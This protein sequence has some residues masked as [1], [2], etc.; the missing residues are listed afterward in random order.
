MYKVLI[1]GDRNWKVSYAKVI[2]RVIDELVAE[3]GTKNL[4]IIEGGAPGVDSLVK[5][6]AHKANIHVAEIEALWNVRGHS[7]GPQRNKVMA[8]LDPNEIIG[9]HD[10][11]KESVGTAGMLK[12][13]KR[14]GIPY[15]HIRT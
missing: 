14:R 3:H 13:A 15:R 6:A 1:C 4:L 9:I 11:I 2:R 10:S 5:L 12:I 7:A 8:A